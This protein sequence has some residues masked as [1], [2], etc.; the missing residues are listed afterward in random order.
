MF[1]IFSY[2]PI[3]IKSPDVML[4]GRQK[5]T[6][7]EGMHEKQVLMLNLELGVGYI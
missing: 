3:I 4:S 1:L 5:K 6:R 7:G 2:Y